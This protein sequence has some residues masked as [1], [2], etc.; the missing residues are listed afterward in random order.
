MK[1][2]ITGGLGF[3]GSNFIRHMLTKYPDYKIINFDKMTYAGNPDNV[4][5]IENNP[6]YSFI[7]GDICDREAVKAAMKDCEWVVN[8]A[9]ESH[10][11]RSI[12]DASDFAKTNFYGVFILLDVAK[13][14]NVKKFLQISTDEVYGSIENG[15]FKETDILKPNSPYSAAKAGADLLARSYFKTFNLP[16]IITRSANNYGPYQYPEKFIPL[17]V[18]NALEDKPL[19]LY[20]DGLNVRDWVYVEDNCKGIDLVLHKGKIG[21]VYNIGGEC[22][23]ANIEIAKKIVEILGK[24]ESLIQKVADR[25]GHDRRYALDISKIKSLGFQPNNNFHELFDKTV[26]WYKE[27]E[28][29]WRKLKK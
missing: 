29:W 11:D 28:W 15:L 4:K 19:P 16:V 12:K 8:F 20:G 9:A 5:D 24:P 14:L 7:K 17:F 26:S 13:E 6:N 2:L 21:E 10:V 1:I 22:E 3:I 27:N 25:L 23:K 18:T